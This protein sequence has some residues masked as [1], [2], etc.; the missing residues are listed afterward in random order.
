MTRPRRQSAARG[1][2]PRRGP[3]GPDCKLRGGQGVLIIKTLQVLE[4]SCLNL[5]G[6]RT[7]QFA[8]TA[9][10]SFTCAREV[11]APEGKYAV[12]LKALGETF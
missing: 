7:L 12:P 8:R 5:T 4:L 11:T 9:Q 10:P 2:A 6:W 3:S 1:Y